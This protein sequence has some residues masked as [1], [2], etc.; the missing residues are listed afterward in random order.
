MATRLVS[1]VSLVLLHAC[2]S[3]PAQRASGAVV[4]AD[5]RARAALA[6]EQAIDVARIPARSF[7]VL[8]FAAPP[9]TLLTPLRFGLA[10]LLI[11]DLA[12]SP[13]LQL[14]ER[15]ETDALLREL[16]LVDAGV[17]DPKTAPRVGRLAGARRLLLGDVAFVDG[18]TIRLSAR[19]VDAVAGTVEELVRADA[20]IAR[21]LDAEKALA[22][23]IFERLGI[24]LT[25]AQREQVEQ[26]Q[27]S[28][29][30]ALVAYGKGV[31]AEAHADVSR[32]Q[33]AYRQATRI[34]PAFLAPARAARGT[35]RSAIRP[36]GLTS[37]ERL[38]F[39]LTNVVNAPV[40]TRVAEAADVPLSPGTLASLG[41][42]ILIT[43]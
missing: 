7:A 4:A 28:Q 35:V 25:A 14:V 30:A 20:P 29:L 10:A 18:S 24:T 2:A 34:D 40:G 8:P 39:Q 3:S 16:A 15:L 43:R 32:A 37:G 13:Q 36:G 22:L 11:T 5:Q 23:Q 21:V 42:L 19:V 31:D 6:G 12:V 27:T 9:D 17:V 33:D 41:F 1:L 38:L 26:R